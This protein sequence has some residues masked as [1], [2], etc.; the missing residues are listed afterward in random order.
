MVIYYEIKVMNV[1][2]CKGYVYID[3]RVLDIDIVLFV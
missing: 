2:G 3:D 1:G